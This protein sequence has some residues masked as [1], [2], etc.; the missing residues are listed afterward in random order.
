MLHI[1]I[2]VTD[3]SLSLDELCHLFQNKLFI[4]FSNGT[5]TERVD[6]TISKIFAVFKVKRIPKLDISNYASKMIFSS[7]VSG[8]AAENSSILSYYLLHKL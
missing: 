4:F 1:L 3:E 7:N 2:K 6:E 5:S 8:D